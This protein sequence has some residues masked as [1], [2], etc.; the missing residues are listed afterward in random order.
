MKGGI[1]P[2]M[3]LAELSAMMK[4]KEKK[5]LEVYSTPGTR[6]ERLIL[7]KAQL[8]ADFDVTMDLVRKRSQAFRSDDATNFGW[9][10]VDS[11]EKKIDFVIDEYFIELRP[12]G[13]KSRF[14]HFLTK[15]G[16]NLIS[17]EPSEF[18]KRKT[19]K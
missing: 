2:K 19:C 9:V 6:E 11:R 17:E 13:Y 15:T 7:V 5:L 8:T 12:E 3:T 10:T 4:A 14:E 1:T 18:K 16:S